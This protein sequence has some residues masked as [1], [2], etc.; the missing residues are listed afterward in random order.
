[1]NENQLKTW[2][3][4]ALLQ[5]LSALA[6]NNEIYKVLIFKGALILN[7]WLG[8][9]RMSL[10][11]DSNLDLDFSL[12]LPERSDQKAFLEKH[13][14]IAITRYFEKQDPVRYEYTGVKVNLNPPQKDHPLGWNAFKVK[15]SLFDNQNAGVRGLPA[16]E[17]DIAAPEKLTGSSVARIQWNGSYIRAYTLERIAGEKARAFLSTL[18]SYREK[19]KKPGEAIRTK[20]LYDLTRIIALKPITDRKFWTAAGAEFRLACESRHI[21]CLGI[22]TFQEDWK[23]TEEAY[24]NDPII[25]KDIDFDKVEQTVGS[26]AEYWLGLRIIP[27]EFPL[28]EEKQF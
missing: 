13:I 7:R 25:P 19:V 27:F 1:M 23:T 16:L 12:E 11:I 17:L 3:T 2:K 8:T 6:E 18:P 5:V 20:D 28:P 15:I 14:P 24:R 26:I 21:D 9:E 22:E 10:D 4:I